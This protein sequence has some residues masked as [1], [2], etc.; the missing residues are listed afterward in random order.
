[1]AVKRT[2]RGSF[3]FPVVIYVTFWIYSIYGTKNYSGS[4]LNADDF[5]GFSLGGTVYYFLPI[6]ILSVSDPTAALVGKKYRLW[7]YK[8][9]SD[10]KTIIGSFAFF[11]SALLL[12][13]LFLIP[14]CDTLIHAVTL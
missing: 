14:N 3:L 2:T 7:P 11:V 6:L 12:S 4:N 10:T 13:L 9:F 1:N 8:I 5:H